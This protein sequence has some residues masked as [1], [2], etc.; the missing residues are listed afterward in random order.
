MLAAG[1]DDPVGRIREDLTSPNGLAL[2]VVERQPAQGRGP[3]AV[4]IAELLARDHADKLSSGAWTA[5]TFCQRA[6]CVTGCGRGP[7]CWPVPCYAVPSN[8]PFPRPRRRAR[9]ARRFPRS[10]HRER[11]RQRRAGRPCQLQDAAAASSWDLQTTPTGSDRVLLIGTKNSSTCTSDAA[12]TPPDQTFLNSTPAAPA[13]DVQRHRLADG[14]PAD[15]GVTP[16]DDPDV[17]N[18]T[19]A[20]PLTNVLC[21]QYQLP[22]SSGERRASPRR[23]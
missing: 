9:A 8:A 5:L 3:N 22:P 10:P 13:A 19:S 12:T 20:N 11:Q 23:R 1:D 18:R 16:C 17:A 6:R 4:Q 7:G 2:F 15:A 21:V 14:A